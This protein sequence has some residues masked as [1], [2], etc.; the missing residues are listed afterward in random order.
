[1][2]L[3][4]GIGA[5]GPPRAQALAPTPAYAPCADSNNFACGHVRVP[6]DRTGATPG[7]ITLAL[8]RHRAPVGEARDAVI[9]LAGGPGQAALPFA[10]QFASVLG[11]IIATRDLIV[12]DQRG[13]GLSDPL[14]CRGVGS[15]SGG[16]REG[17][18][19]AACA[20]KIGRARPFFTTDQSV[21]DIEA[22]RQ[23]GGYEKLIL[24][25]TSYGT[26]VAERYA[27]SYPTH[28]EGLVLDSVVPPN[29]PDPL[30]RSTFAAVPRVLRQL[31]AGRACR[32][33]THSPRTDLMRLVRRIGP[34]GLRAHWIDGHGRPR[35]IKIS[36]DDVLE[37]LLAGDME[38]GL[39]AEFP[40]AVLS[41]ARGDDAALA[42]MLERAESA[43]ASELEAGGF[44][45]ALDLDTSCEEQSFPWNR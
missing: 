6:I 29:G 33:V 19:I 15:S 34:R 21:A 14:S 18:A 13:T 10:E 24:Y 30:N 16:G 4:A 37:A 5:T 3:A 9:A 20:A 25:G 12:F 43:E 39:R 8:R 38:P 36:S 7:T 22:I 1:M 44:D 26:K 2:I 41:A 11:P 45:A 35:A 28:V 27:Q 32:R 17:P 42:R 40:A 23:A 31:C